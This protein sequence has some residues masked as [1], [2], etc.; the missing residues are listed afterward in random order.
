MQGIKITGI[1]VLGFILM[2]LSSCSSRFILTGNSK[3]EYRMDSLQSADPEIVTEYLP[4]KRQLDSSMNTVIGTTEKALTKEYDTP[5]TLLGDFFCEALIQQARLIGVTADFCLAT[6]GGLRSSLPA[7]NITVGNIFELMPFEN[8][9]VTVTL[10]GSDVRKV[11]EFIAR[12]GGQPE[13]GI[14]MTIRSKT[15]LSVSINGQPPDE[16][17]IYTMLTYDYLAGGAEH[18]DFL[19][20]LPQQKLQKKVRDALLEYVRNQTAA[21]K[22]INLNTDG[23]I[24]IET[25]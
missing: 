21:G 18:L 11:I 5:E 16:N 14:R 23:R 4:Y 12:S 13:A 17:R 2:E 9:L 19:R 7:G 20:G 1:A 10:K 8:E 6:K 22:K 24:I 3:K 25:P 15:A